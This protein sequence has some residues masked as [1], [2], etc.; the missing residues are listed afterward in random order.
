VRFFHSFIFSF[1]F[2][3]FFFVTINNHNSFLCWLVL[4]VLMEEIQHPLIVECMFFQMF[5]F[6]FLFAIFIR[7]VCHFIHYFLTFFF[8]I[9]CVWT[10]S[11]IL[12]SYSLCFVMFCIFNLH[13]PTLFNFF[14]CRF[15]VC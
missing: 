13:C 8:C 2:T 12:T 15:C 14:F 5:V 3:L 9:C 4:H 11:F 7:F 1:Q 10:F 6:S